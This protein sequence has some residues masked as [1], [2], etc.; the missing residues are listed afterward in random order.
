MCIFH[1]AQVIL[2]IT[3]ATINAANTSQLCTPIDVTSSNSSLRVIFKPLE[4]KF[5][6][7]G[8]DAHCKPVP[9]TI[10]LRS[11]SGSGIQLF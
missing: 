7:F 11:P 4:T 5:A 6:C 1:H 3:N 2:K 10:S 9:R 8:F